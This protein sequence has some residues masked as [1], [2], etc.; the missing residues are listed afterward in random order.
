LISRIILIGLFFSITKGQII[1]TL[2]TINVSTYPSE[3]KLQHNLI[4]DTTFSIINKDIDSIE[5][6][7][8]PINGLLY[9][10]KQTRISK[11]IIVTYDYYAISLP[12]KIGP[13]WIDLPLID[14]LMLDNDQSKDIELTS[15][16]IVKEKES[17]YS[18]GTFFRNLNIAPRGGSEFSGG[19]QMQIQGSL[20]DDIEVGGVL[21][22]QNFPIQPDGNTSNLDEIDKIFFQI[23]HNNFE[24]RAGD[25]DIDIESGK[26]LNVKRKTVGVNNQFKFNGVSGNGAVAGSKGVSHQIEFKGVDGKQGPYNLTAKNGN[27]DIIIIAGSE[28]VWLNGV[29]LHRGEDYDY[30]IDYS[31]GEIFFMPKNIIFFDSD[32]FIEYQ[33]GDEQYNRNLLSSSINKELNNRGK[34][35]LSWIREYD[36]TLNTNNE[37]N[38][39]ALSLFKESGDREIYV[40]GSIEDS[41]GIYILLDSVYIFDSTNTIIGQHYQVSF[42]YDSKNGQYV[43][44]LSNSGA[45]YYQWVDRK[46]IELINESIDYYSPLRELVAPESHQLV[47][48]LSNYRVNHWLDLS[49]EMALSDYDRNNMSSIDDN[50]NQGIGHQIKISGDQI[51]LTN[52]LIIGYE[53]SQ[54]GRNKKFHSLQRDRAIEF[55]QDWNILPLYDKNELMQNFNSTF[56]IDSLLL[57]NTNLSRYTIGSNRKERVQLDFKGSTNFFNK[58]SGKINQVHSNNE[59]YQTIDFNTKLFSG[60]IHP[61]IDY[62]NEYSDKLYHFNHLTSGLQFN[63]KQLQSILGFGQREDYIYNDNKE[64]LFSKGYFGEVDIKYKSLSGWNHSIVYRKRI[65]NEFIDDQKI[66]YDLLQTR[67]FLRKPRIPLRYDAKFKIEEVL[68]EQ[69]MAVY[70][71]VG[72]GLGTHRY[73]IQFEEYVP[74][75]NGAYIA[76]TVLSGSRRPTTK[77]EGIQ[78]LEYDF[79]KKYKTF[80]K[81]IKYRMDWKWDF[82]GNNFHINK[83]RRN[84]LDSE[85]VV[86]SKSKL[87]NEINYLNQKGNQIKI[88]NVNERDL[89]SLDPR[90][91]DLR[92]NN[93]N[94]V[95]YLKPIMREM[96][97]GLKLDQHRIN[98]KS[99]FSSLR[100]RSA[101][102][103]WSE[104]GLKKRFSSVLHIEGY[105][106]YGYDEGTHQ[107][108]SYS[109]SLKGV[110]F[111]LLHFF[112]SKGRI[113]TR[114]EWSNV[115]LFGEANY[116]PPE[117][118][119]GNAVGENR[120]VTINGNIFLKDNFSININI[121]YISDIRY[122]NFINMS[123][124]L[125]AYF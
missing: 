10:T 112:S 49:F 87:L 41:S 110:Q 56:S 103:Y 109:S 23:N 74:D 76:Y 91:P 16:P 37:I 34:I 69:R 92:I 96:H 55:N 113:Q 75:P 66:N 107:L 48:A 57:V 33:Y 14:S 18:S 20:G 13:K 90:G 6:S 19:F 50:D 73:D 84:N 30:T 25:V 59:Y 80:L 54:W 116:L 35:Q 5:Y 43:R 101:A 99:S 3:I 40:T 24:I 60:S 39:D 105:L 114:F 61:V 31:L 1:S 22:D 108:N 68:T 89:N 62:K 95:D 67:I 88:W 46:N 98:I 9:V 36:Q 94:G 82:N 71:S 97:F 21:S 17:I 123:G 28:R 93:E 63:G 44:K 77:F 29:R 7:L 79:S 11:P 104:I 26:Y 45:L 115:D 122:D 81:N 70:D 111:D 12:I 125:R 15:Y 121:N 102:G 38:S 120:R 124:E 51:A 100:D 83:Y 53:V 4:I 8:D 106:Q 52:N 65:K 118:L 32:L 27:K 42:T 64:V 78:R 47:Q 58:I 85:S 2:D 72:L 119:R 117:A 86:R